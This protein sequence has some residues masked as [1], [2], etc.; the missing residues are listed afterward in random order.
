MSV[1]P[2]SHATANVVAP[3]TG[4]KD[5]QAARSV[6]KVLAPDTSPVSKDKVT[7]SKD[8]ATLKVAGETPAQEAAE[9]PVET[10]REANKGDSQAQR[11]LA[12][13]AAAAEVQKPPV[14]KTEEARVA[15]TID[16]MV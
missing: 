16:K 1:N 11:L 13:Q 6:A 5:D 14:A 2:L 12:K 8:S 9:A 4:P 3:Q 7:I 10:A 15:S